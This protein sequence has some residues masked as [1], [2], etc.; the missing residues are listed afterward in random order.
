MYVNEMNELISRDDYFACLAEIVC[1][2]FAATGGY[3]QAS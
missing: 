3:K 1:P 2:F